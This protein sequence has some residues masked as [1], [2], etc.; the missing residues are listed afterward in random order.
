MTT[1]A[2]EEAAN[3]P[4]VP[5]SEDEFA[6]VKRVLTGP[7]AIALYVFGVL[8]VSFHLYGLL[9]R[10]IDPLL[11]RAIHLSGGMVL[12]F[13]IHAATAASPRHRLSVV[14]IAL[15]AIAVAAAGYIWWELDGLQF[16]AGA[17]WTPGDTIVGF[18]G[19]ALTLEFARRTAGIALPIIAGV[20]LLYCFVGPWLPWFLHHNGYEFGQLFSYIFSDQ[21]IFGDTIQVSA[22]FIIMFVCFGAFL[23]MSKVGD[24]FNDLAISLV[25][26]ARGGPA[27]ATVISGVLFGTVSGSSV[28]NVV[29]SGS[30]T[31]PMMRKVGYDRATAGAVEATSSTGGQLTPPVMGA[32]AFI[33]AELL[34]RPYTEIAFAAIIP[35]LLFY[36][37]CYVHCDLHAVRHGLRGLPRGELPPIGAIVRRIYMLLPIIVLVTTFIQGY[38][39]FRAAAL[40]IL[41]A[42]VVS[43][44]NLAPPRSLG[45]ARDTAWR[46]AASIIGALERTARD[47]VQ[48]VAICACAGIIVGVIALTGLGGRFAQLLLAIAGQN[49]VLALVFTMIVTVI[50]GMG[51]PTTAAYAVAASVVAPGLLK[52]GIPPLTAHMFIFYYAVLSAITPPVAVASFAAA[53]IAKADPWRTSW[54]AVRLGLATMIVPFMFFVSPLLLGQGA[55]LDVMYVFGTAALGV[56]FLAASTEGWLYGLVPLPLRV[57]LFIAAICLI[58][59]EGS[60]DLIGAAIGGGVFLVQRLRAR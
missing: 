9:L 22:T 55:F 14:D 7:A 6:G 19:T 27:K 4:A 31:I 10:P 39:G 2:D 28:A 24:Y 51:M 33:M 26:W 46:F 3:A 43:L 8:Y 41:T 23:Q 5:V 50:L 25:G 40:A 54:I 29:A 49:Q 11:Y 36:T 1:K 20:F 56:F 53:G 47:V 15:I 37:A 57:L 60:T 42:I 12:G 35:C 44:T 38:S 30:L 13:S 34:G 48:L 21:G 16:R 52:I 32:G 18:V 58:V 17:M 59:P 45:E